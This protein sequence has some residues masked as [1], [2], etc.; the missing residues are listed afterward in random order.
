MSVIDIVMDLMGQDF[1]NFLRAGPQLARVLRVLRVSRLFKVMKSKQFDGVFRILQTLIFSL[2]SLLNV[3]ALLGLVYFIYAVLGVFLFKDAPYDS[4]YNSEWVSFS[5]FGHAFLI[6]FR[7][8]T[9]YT[10]AISSEFSLN[11]FH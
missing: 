6:L 2:P 3:M 7:C 10:T 8:S 9:G 4:E 11:F 1:I 5:N